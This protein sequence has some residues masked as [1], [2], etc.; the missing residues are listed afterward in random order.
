[1]WCSCKGT[2]G[3]GGKKSQASSVTYPSSR[4]PISSISARRATDSA[5]H[6]ATPRFSMNAGSSDRESEQILLTLGSV[7]RRRRT[8]L[9]VCL[10]GVLAVVLYYNET[11]PPL[12]EASA[13]VVFEELQGPLPD[14]STNLSRELYLFDRIEEINSRAF[15][16]DVA[17][18]LPPEALPR[19]PM[20]EKRSPDFDRMRQ[21]SEL[22]HEGIS[23]YPLRNSNIVRIRVRLSDPRLCMDVARLC[24]S[25]LEERTGQTRSK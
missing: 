8:V 11:T 22:I 21:V 15:A 12:Y 23:A 20:P 3:I 9:A 14:V 6:A 7:L 10:L 1:M 2:P 19:I 4:A 16:D 5:L 17:A 24:L 18:A 13:S 25:V